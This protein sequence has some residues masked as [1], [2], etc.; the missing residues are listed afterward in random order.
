MIPTTGTRNSIMIH[1]RVAEG[2]FLSRNMIVNAMTKLTRKSPVIKDD[3]FNN[4]RENIIT[5][6]FRMAYTVL[7]S[8][9]HSVK[10]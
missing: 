10:R 9:K 8:M 4:V 2:F 6:S 5:Q 3:I 1:A 7:E